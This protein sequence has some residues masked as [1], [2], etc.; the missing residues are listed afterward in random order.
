MNLYSSY[1]FIHFFVWFISIT[2]HLSKLLWTDYNSNTQICMKG[3]TF[4]NPGKLNR[5]Q[6]FCWT[7]QAISEHFNWFGWCKSNS[8]WVKQEKIGTP[9]YSSLDTGVR[10]P[11]GPPASVIFQCFPSSAFSL[12]SPISVQNKWSVLYRVQKKTP[13]TGLLCTVGCKLFGTRT[14]LVNRGFLSLCCK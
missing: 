7:F 14:S 5:F 13:E 11:I 9:S 3:G 8:G 6:Q 2:T 4:L 1:L 10:Y 12:S